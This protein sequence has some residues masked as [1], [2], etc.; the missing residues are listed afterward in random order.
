ML[1]E[2]EKG[3]SLPAL[4]ENGKCVVH[5]RKEFGKFAQTHFV[6]RRISGLL[7]T[8]N[9]GRLIHLRC[10]FG[11]TLVKAHPQEPA[12]QWSDRTKKIFHLAAV[13][14]LFF[15]FKT[16]VSCLVCSSSLRVFID[17][18]FE[19]PEQIQVYYGVRAV[20]NE[21]RSK[22]TAEYPAGERF[23][24]RTDLNNQ[25]ARRLRID[26]GE[27]VGAMRL[28]G[29]RLKSFFF[30]EETRFSAA[31]IARRFAPGPGVT[32][33]LARDGDEYVEVLSESDDPYI[34]LRDALRHRGLFLSWILPLVMAVGAYLL[35][36][37]FSPR[38][39]PA[40]ADLLDQKQSSAGLHFAVLDGIR[41]LAALAVLGVHVGLVRKGIGVIGVLLFF[42]L[43][44]FL[45]AIPFARNPDRAVSMDYMRAYMKRR[46]LRIIPMYYTIIT[47]LFL[48][49]RKLPD[50]FRHYL[51]LQGDGYLWTVPQEMF[52]YI[53]LPALVVALYGL[54]WLKKRFAACIPSNCGAILQIL[55]PAALLVAAAA[56]TSMAHRMGVTLYGDGTTLP[57]MVG[58]FINGMFFSY[59][60]QALQDNPFWQG[61]HGKRLYGS[62]NVAGFVILLF[63]ALVSYGLVPGVH[64]LDLY[65]YFGYSGF[66]TSFIIF[67]VVASPGS[68]LARCMSW[69]PLRAIGVVSFSFYLLHPTFIVTC[70][71]TARYFWGIELEPAALMLVVTPVSYAASACTYSWI[72]R[73]FMKH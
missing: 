2:E 64:H 27:H 38:A 58:V 61:I 16:A 54:T 10:L 65:K 1:E 73:P 50:V 56:T 59:L 11:D 60:Y 32:M 5:L 36:S 7:H 57:A 33:R 62:L 48:F 14:L 19:R 70:R 18:R 51:F 20:F 9:L 63:F 17:A 46:L 47:V 8:E 37:G 3:G 72:E 25:V 35:V 40:F 12:V 42:S 30:H 68:M 69:T 53:L 22:K 66:L 55:E 44:G 6:S 39:F 71:E 15:C 23:E 26:L 31:D 21:A 13:I 67:A 49:P 43:S 34:V 29:L 41:G 52:F 24:G 45:L 4:A 28:Y